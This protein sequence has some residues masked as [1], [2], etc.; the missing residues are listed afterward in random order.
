LAREE[1]VVTAIATRASAA[2][3]AVVAVEAE[4][5]VALRHGDEAEVR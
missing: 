1:E 5:H 4:Q 3:L 2:R